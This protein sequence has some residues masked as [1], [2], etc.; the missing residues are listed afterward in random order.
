M[1]LGYRD[2][3][4]MMAGRFGIQADRFIA[5]RGRLDHLRKRGCP[6]DVNSGKGR[7]AE[8]GWRQVIELGL[9]LDL[10]HAG[11]APEGVARVMQAERLG[12]LFWIQGMV[13]AATSSEMVT[14]VVTDK[15]NFESTVFMHLRAFA[16]NALTP[17][18]NENAFC[19]EFVAGRDITSWLRQADDFATPLVLVDLGSRLAN[20]LTSVAAW[21]KIPIPEL[22]DQ[23]R[24]WLASEMQLSA[25]GILRDLNP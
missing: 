16:L 10:V 12:I 4:A 11:L 24:D 7:P 3:E 25:E 6:S 22:V 8:F 23:F 13:E 2:V 20:L 19:V 5:F 15:W 21:S 17:A 14:A 9:A 18:G 1:K